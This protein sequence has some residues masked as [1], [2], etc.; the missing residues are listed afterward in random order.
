MDNDPHTRLDGR[1]NALR[2]SASF[3]GGDRSLSRPR[4]DHR[5]PALQLGAA[6]EATTEH[7]PSISKR[8]WSSSIN[9]TESR[10]AVQRSR[11]P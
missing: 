4:N 6:P 2:L 5:S 8:L 7:N 11:E 3:A 9:V 10:S 1:P